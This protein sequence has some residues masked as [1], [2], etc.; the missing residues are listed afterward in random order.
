MEGFSYVLRV[1]FKHFNHNRARGEEMN[2]ALNWWSRV[3]SVGEV[4]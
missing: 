4:H 2:K 1:G 3:R